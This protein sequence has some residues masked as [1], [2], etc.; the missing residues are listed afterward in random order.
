MEVP[1]IPLVSRA[2]LALLLVRRGLGSAQ[3]YRRSIFDLGSSQLR[4]IKA[5][6]GVSTDA[7]LA[8]CLLIP[9]SGCPDLP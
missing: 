3:L 1:S 8:F 7:T 2:A 9:A 6:L 4:R 5:S